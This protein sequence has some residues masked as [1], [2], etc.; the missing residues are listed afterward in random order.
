[1]RIFLPL[2][3]FYAVRLLRYFVIYYF[4]LY[5]SYVYW[6]ASGDGDYDDHDE[7]VLPGDPCACAT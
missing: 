7:L 4:Y 1:M 6:P 5:L 3:Y 2:F